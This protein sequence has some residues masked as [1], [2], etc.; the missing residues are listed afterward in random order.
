MSARPSVAELLDIA[1]RFDGRDFDHFFKKV[2]LLRAQRQ[3]SVLPKEESDLLQKINRGF[4]DHKWQRLAALNDQL[5]YET[6]DETEHGELMQLIDEYE[7][8]MVQRVR[9]LGRLAA[10]RKVSLEELVEQLGIN[11]A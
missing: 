1:A 11:H 2:V 3:P 4:P 6:L 7:A 9:Y 8:Y 10:L 5:E